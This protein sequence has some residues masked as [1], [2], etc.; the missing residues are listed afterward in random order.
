VTGYLVSPRARQDLFEITDYIADDNLDAA[1][2]LRDRLFAA[3]DVLAKQPN[4]GHVRSDLAPAEFGVRFWPVGTYLVI[5]RPAEPA[6]QI[7]RV[8][9]GYR[10]IATILGQSSD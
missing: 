4:L 7:V 6:I 1:L 2:R 8:L 10:D 5:Y 3:F 9:S